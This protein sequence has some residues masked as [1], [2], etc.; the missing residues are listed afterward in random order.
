[1]KYEIIVNGTF[2][3]IKGIV[4]S[5]SLLL[6]VKCTS[7]QFIHGKQVVLCEESIAYNDK[8]E[9]CNLQIACSSC[10]SKMN[11][12]IY[13]PKLS[14]KIIIEGQTYFIGEKREN[15][16]VVSVVE[17]RGAEVESIENVKFSVI[18]DNDKVFDN[19][20]CSDDCWTAS[21]E[22]G[23]VY[24]IEDLSFDFARIK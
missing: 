15:S 21:D 12:Y 17:C 18:T 7:C 24:S 14:E 23:N 13:K 11:F 9:K 2:S 16:F 8:N 6:K 19:A 3:K 4:G 5:Q 22:Y 1:M 10:K 20:D